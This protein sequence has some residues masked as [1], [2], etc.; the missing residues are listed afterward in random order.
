MPGPSAFSEG[1]LELTLMIPAQAAPHVL[2]LARSF[3]A[4][5]SQKSV[6]PVVDPTAPL[7]AACNAVTA[8]GTRVGTPLSPRER[9]VL[10]LVGMGLIDT[11]I[12]R[13]L[14]IS[15]HTVRTHLRRSFAKL[16]VL[17]RAEAVARTVIAFDD[18][19]S[20]SDTAEAGAV[21]HV[22]AT[23]RRASPDS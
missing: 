16:G 7:P 21:S 9:E 10:E 23:V 12:G 18:L 14:G 20:E 22:P 2:A 1:R 4:T 11:A 5:Y 19:V 17:N 3:G 15:A 8:E 6:G 13:S